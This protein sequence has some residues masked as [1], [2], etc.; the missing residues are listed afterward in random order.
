MRRHGKNKYSRAEKRT[1]F[2]RASELA[3]SGSY[4]NSWEIEQF[5]PGLKDLLSPTERV[6]LDQRCRAAWKKREPPAS[7]PPAQ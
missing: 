4:R 6:N 5:V 7:A 2:V 1:A 3:D